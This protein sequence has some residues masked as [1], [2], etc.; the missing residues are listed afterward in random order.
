MKLLEIIEIKNNKIIL[1]EAPTA[2]QAVI[3]PVGNQFMVGLNDP[4]GTTMLFDKQADAEK[5]RDDWQRTTNSSQQQQLI[6]ANESKK[7]TRWQ[8]SSLAAKA[9]QFENYIR[10]SPFIAK[11]SNNVLFGYLM[12]GFAAAGISVAIWQGILVAIQDVKDDNSLSE[13]DRQREIGVLISMFYV[14]LILALTMIFRSVNLIKPWLKGFR[15]VIR[16]A[17]AGAIFTGVGALPSFISML[18]TESGYFV[19]LWALS[20]PDVQRYFSTWIADTLVADIF[21]EFGR[22]AVP[23]VAAM[24]D[25]ATGGLV[26]SPNLNRFFRLDGND[27]VVDW[28]KANYVASAEWAKL[29]FKG[30]L[31]GSGEKQ[32]VPYIN[33]EQRKLLLTER[34]NE[35]F[36]ITE[37]AGG[38]T[39]DQ[40]AAPT[41]PG[42]ARPTVGGPGALPAASPE[43]RRDAAAFGTAQRAASWRTREQSLRT[44]YS[45]PS[46]NRNQPVVGPR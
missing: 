30:I 17:Q 24:L 1:K 33:P 46:V 8:K 44:D 26:G 34:I 18:I 20:N 9:N 11:V 40:A 39:A 2:P 21:A 7:Q 23:A 37:P 31:F 5:F 35:M 45:N 6:N 22:T 25:R 42:G 36:N 27:T 3:S 41:Q 14:E 28:D 4:D 12:R 19:V 16:T 13:D 15:A 10:R 38:Q 29:I 43:A 32:Q